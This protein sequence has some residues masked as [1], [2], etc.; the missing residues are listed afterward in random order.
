MTGHQPSGEFREFKFSAMRVDGQLYETAE[1]IPRFLRF[2]AD[3]WPR[4]C[5]DAPAHLRDIA[6]RHSVALLDQ[7]L[8]AEPDTPGDEV[9]VSLPREMAGYIARATAAYQSENEFARPTWELIEALRK[10]DP[11]HRGAPVP[12][13]P[14]RRRP[15]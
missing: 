2:L 14:V 5:V 15:G 11:D 1:N 6:D 10:L 4:G 8:S 3:N 13:N 9:E 7:Y 12:R